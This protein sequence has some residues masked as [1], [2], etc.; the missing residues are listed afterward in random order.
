MTHDLI[1]IVQAAVSVLV[2]VLI[3][4]Q[5]RSSAGGLGGLFGAS[6]DGGFYQTRRG[7]EKFLFWATIALIAVFAGLALLNLVI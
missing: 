6:G 5:E 1:S 3:L 4:V 7:M 2:I